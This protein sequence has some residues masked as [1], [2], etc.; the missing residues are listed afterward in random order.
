MPDAALPSNP[1]VPVPTWD[2]DL[3]FETL[4]DRPRR[5]LLVALAARGPQPASDLMGASGRR[6]DATLK[7]LASLRSSGLVVQQENP[8]DG[9]KYLYALA[10]TVPIVRTEKGAA[11]EFG[12]CAVRW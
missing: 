2:E 10:P 3:I 6:L 4:A 9:R 1:S 5:R 11:L 8:G 7:H 12:F